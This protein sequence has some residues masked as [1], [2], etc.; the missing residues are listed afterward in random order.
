MNAAR[1]RRNDTTTFQGCRVRDDEQQVLVEQLAGDFPIFA[2]STI[3]RWVAHES[4][5]YEAAQVPDSGPL[6]ARSVRT[7]LQE[8]SR[9]GV[10]TSHDLP[11][12]RRGLKPDELAGADPLT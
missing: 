1:R 2:R 9:E 12:A 10:A 4:A 8:L 6:V 11:V 7:T 5:K 3:A